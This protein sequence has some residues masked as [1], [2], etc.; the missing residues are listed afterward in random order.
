MKSLFYRDI[1]PTL[2]VILIV[3][4]LFGPVIVESFS[5][6]VW[7]KIRPSNGIYNIHNSYY[8]YI[9][10]SLILL[11]F[12]LLQTFIDKAHFAMKIF[13]VSLLFTIS[14]PVYVQQ[15][16]FVIDD[17]EKE[18][19]QNSQIVSNKT[20]LSN[21]EQKITILEMKLKEQEDIIFQLKK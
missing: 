7:D 9:S 10:F 16:R 5:L 3:Y 6:D 12:T 17:T 8:F 15:N 20:Y 18:K 1:L 21:L 2:I 11:F 4:L 14:I 19:E 13:I